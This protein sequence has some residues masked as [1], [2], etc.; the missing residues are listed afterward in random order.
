MAVESITNLAAW[1]E[2]FVFAVDYES[3]YEINYY[4]PV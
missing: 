3:F 2:I 1:R 4:L